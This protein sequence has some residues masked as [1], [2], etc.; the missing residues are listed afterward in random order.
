MPTPHPSPEA[1]RGRRPI[2]GGI[3]AA[4]L[5]LFAI[6]FAIVFGPAVVA[7]VRVFS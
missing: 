6:L 2:V 3:F 4:L 7:L 5:A 1:A